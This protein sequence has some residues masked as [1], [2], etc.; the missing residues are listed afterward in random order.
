MDINYLNRVSVKMREKRFRILILFL[1]ASIAARDVT[2]ATKK[3][4]PFPNVYIA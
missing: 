1:V 2:R 3:C 4:H